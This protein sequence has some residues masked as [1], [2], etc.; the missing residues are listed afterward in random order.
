RSGDARPRTRR[1]KSRDGGDRLWPFSLDAPA[2]AAVAGGPRGET[3]PPAV[4]PVAPFFGACSRRG[5]AGGNFG[6]GGGREESD[7]RGAAGMRTRDTRCSGRRG[8]N[9]TLHRNRRA[10]G[11]S[12]HRASS[13]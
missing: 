1:K 4:G 7:P 10:G 6:R 13:R 9:A 2:V 5:G 3:P 11:I 8:R 12:V